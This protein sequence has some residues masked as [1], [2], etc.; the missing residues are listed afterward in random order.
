MKTCLLLSKIGEMRKMSVLL[1]LRIKGNEMLLLAAPLNILLGF[2][3]I[4]SG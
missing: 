2:I 1:L 4:K 3:A